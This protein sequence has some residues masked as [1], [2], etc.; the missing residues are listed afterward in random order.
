[1]KYAS[2]DIETTGLDDS[3]CQML[4]FGCVLDDMIRPIEECPTFHCY[5]VRERYVGQPYALS[6]HAAIF[7]RIA[8]LTPGFNYFTP[9]EAFDK[10][11]AWLFANDFTW[12]G[13]NIVGK[14]FGSFDRNF[15]LRDWPHFK[16]RHRI[17]DVGS[18]FFNPF[19]DHEG[20]P[21][22]K[23]CKDRVGLPGDVAHTAV[24]D[25]MDCVKVIRLR[26]AGA[27][28]QLKQSL[29]KK[30]EVVPEPERTGSDGPAQPDAVRSVA[31]SDSETAAG[32]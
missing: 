8:D 32:S 26:Y 30:D 7:R 29:E 19:Y 14:N 3:F 23:A 16:S 5:I 1:M 31:G 15:I 27:L 10:F 22:L 18:A 13:L 25:A 6:M 20:L 4:E 28:E 11:E 21:D 12:K 24:E 9:Q 17:L 2:I